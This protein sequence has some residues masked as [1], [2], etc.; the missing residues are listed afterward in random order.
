[1]P[2][3]MASFLAKE[4]VLS[5]YKPMPWEVQSPLVVNH[6]ERSPSP[7]SVR[8]WLEFEGIMER[9]KVQVCPVE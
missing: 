2:R 8:L 7:S 9:L 5:M 4:S 3:R 1:M 6:L